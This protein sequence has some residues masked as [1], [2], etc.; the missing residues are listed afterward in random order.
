MQTFQIALETTGRSGSL[1]VL[2]REMVVW[3]RHLPTGQRAAAGLAVELKRAID[4]CEQRSLA[5]QWISVA[6][7]PGSF[8][9]LR[10]AITTAKS[11][12][13]AWGI[14]IVPV[15]STQAIAAALI[16]ERVCDHDQ[17]APQLSDGE[18]IPKDP[19]AKRVLV[20]LN[21]FRGQV[22]VGDYRVRQ[23]L[24][25]DACL[26][27][28]EVI[29]QLEWEDRLKTQGDHTWVTGDAA[30]FPPS[31]ADRNLVRSEGDAV[32]VGLVA[33]RKMAAYQLADPETHSVCPT[34]DAFLLTANY[35]KR[36]AAEEKVE[37]KA[38]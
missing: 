15:I 5:P 2:D 32:G 12:A 6:N 16:Q 9:G 8:T 23:I 33:W 4:Y 7:G 26:E 18:P 25:G 13:Y 24:D 22:F 28:V 19:P 14:P 3:K 27:D 30:V 37:E 38:E 17:N 10:I 31:D 35:L 11:L 36:S 21:A 20:A 34:V 29:S 1:A